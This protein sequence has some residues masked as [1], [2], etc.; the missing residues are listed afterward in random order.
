MRLV[1]DLTAKAPEEG[2]AVD[3]ALLESARDG[4]TD[5]ARV[6]VCERAVILGR[7]QD[8]VGECDRGAA[9]RYGVAIVRR[10]S[11]GGAV[12]LYPGNL[13]VSL[14][15][16]G[17][18]S[19]GTVDQSFAWFGEVMAGG[20]RSFGLDAV[21]ADRSVTVGG[22]KISGAAQARRGDALLLHATLLVQPDVIAMSALLLAM[23]DGYAPTGTKSRASETTT[24][25][26]ALG[27]R[28]GLVEAADAAVRSLAR[29][30]DRPMTAGSLGVN[31]AAAAR[32]LEAERYRSREWNECR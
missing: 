27:R 7:S 17:A 12:Y 20:V 30:L 4:G 10:V 24:L 16:T 2:L 6:W 26:D 19:F 14:I 23:R 25:T 8:A 21:A 5:T 18:R 1:L 9:A 15:L 29:A 28:V 32:R 3:E 13:N 31:E 22:R 11:G